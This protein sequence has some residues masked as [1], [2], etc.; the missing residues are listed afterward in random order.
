MKGFSNVH[1]SEGTLY[2]LQCPESKCEGIIPPSLLK[3]L[4]GDQEYERYEAVMLE[5]T[6]ECMPDAVCCPRCETICF[7]DEDH[8]AHCYNCFNSFCS[9][10]KENRHLGVDCLT[11]ELKMQ[12]LQGRL[13]SSQLNEK[14]RRAERN[15]INEF[16]SEK[17]I[18]RNTKQ[19]PRCKMAISRIEGC[20][21]MVCGNCGNYFC[22]LCSRSIEGYA[23]FWNG[24][25]KLFPGEEVRRMNDRQTGVQIAAPKVNLGPVHQCGHCARMNTKT[26]DNNYIYCGGC[27]NHYCYLCLTVV[28]N[29]REHFGRTRCKQHTPG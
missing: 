29:F 27:R 21:K 12:I 20:N 11:P 16:L 24:E 14:Q 1:V 10:C 6:L 28:K 23:H 18:A 26:D 7:E 5:K 13:V 4:L 15:K 22:Y 25:C 9:I 8:F 2:K 19:C 3:Q 17:E